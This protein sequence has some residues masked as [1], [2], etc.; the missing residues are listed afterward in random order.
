MPVQT[1]TPAASPQQCSAAC[2]TGPNTGL[3]S[4]INHPIQ[5]P[6]SQPHTSLH[7]SG[8]GLTPLHHHQP[9]LKPARAP[10]IPLGS[11][12]QSPATASPG[13]CCGCWLLDNGNLSRHHSLETKAPAVRQL[14][15]CKQPLPIWLSLHSSLSSPGL[16]CPGRGGCPTA[17]RAEQ[18]FQ[19]SENNKLHHKPLASSATSGG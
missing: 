11:L 4:K 16:H 5:E 6:G 13:P 14:V 18:T 3:G 15:S 12:C 19:Q 2:K 10:S 8:P 9:G 7:Q 17:T 1:T